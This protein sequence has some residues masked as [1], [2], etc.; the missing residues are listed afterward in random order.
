MIKSFKNFTCPPNKI[1]L[2]DA[3]LNKIEKFLD[4][5]FA[6]IG[7]DVEFTKHFK[8]RVNDDRNKKQISHCE[9]VTIFSDVLK[10]H[11]SNIKKNPKDIERII[12]SISTD[13]NIPIVIKW[14]ERKGEI[15]MIAK[16][17]MRKKSFKSNDPQLKVE[18]S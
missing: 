18:N 12:K 15:E 17:V 16:T 6:S 13:I 2:S 10:K 9:L 4:K 3:Q 5:I 1:K 11:G 14:N 7:V 8:E